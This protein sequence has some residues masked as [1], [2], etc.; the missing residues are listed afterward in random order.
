V[1]G[2][3][4]S[5]TAYCVIWLS[6]LFVQTGEVGNDFLD[7][8]VPAAPRIARIDGQAHL[9]YELHITNFRPA[10]VTLTEIDVLRDNVVLHSYTGAELINSVASVGV[11]APT[12]DPQRLDAGRRAIVYAWLSV[13]QGGIPS[14]IRHRVSFRTEEAKERSFDAEPVRVLPVAPAELGPRYAVVLG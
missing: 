12:P 13:S 4:L 2:N 8:H 7:V 14:E 1:T 9:V 5:L 11:R 10:T 6:A 3:Q